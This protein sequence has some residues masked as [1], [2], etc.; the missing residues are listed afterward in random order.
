MNK[1]ATP[2]TMESRNFLNLNLSSCFARSA[3]TSASGDRTFSSRLSSQTR[4]EEGWG[5]KKELRY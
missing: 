1:A 4:M 5:G 3:A 2:A